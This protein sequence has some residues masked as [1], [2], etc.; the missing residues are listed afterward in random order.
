ML[1]RWLKEPLLHFVVLGATL[2]ALHRWVA[3]PAPQRIVLSESVVRGLRQ[4][5][6]RRNGALPTAEEE[7]ALIQRF[8]DN[9]VLYRE[10]LALGLDRGDIIVRRRL[11]QKMEFASEGLEPIPE[12]SDAELQ[13][14]LD[15]HPE[16]YAT[17][18]RVAF[19]HVFV[20][21]DRHAGDADATAVRLRAQLAAGAAPSSLGEPFIRGQELG[22]LSERE[23]GNIFGTSFSEQVMSLPIGGW[24][25]PLRSS[26]GVHLV[27]VT[28]RQEGHPPRLQ[29]VR[30]AARR[31][32]QEERRTAAS[33]AVLDRLRRRYE[34]S[35][36]RSGADTEML[37]RAADAR[38]ARPEEEK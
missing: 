22:L 14:Y 36:D 7:A 15:A 26:Y 31:E 25:A 4:D 12:P 13:D 35:I 21:N 32:W 27:H 33:R 5:H 3:P 30:P 10:A 18:D 19:T 20:S 2:F 8:I 28:Q 17:V 37:A 9:E 23:L 1:D 6:L 38:V 24:S 16:R 34:I 11:V 29:E